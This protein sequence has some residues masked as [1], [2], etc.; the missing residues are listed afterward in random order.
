MNPTKGP[1]IL[2]SGITLGGP[3][4]NGDSRHTPSECTMIL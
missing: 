3:Q 2:L 1:K 4:N